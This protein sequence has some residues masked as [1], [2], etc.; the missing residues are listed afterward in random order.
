MDV[1]PEIRSSSE[2]RISMCWSGEP[3]NVT[4]CLFS[5]AAGIGTF[6]TQSFT[7]K[8]SINAGIK[9]EP[10]LSYQKDF[11]PSKSVI[12]KTLAVSDR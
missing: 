9:S 4:I 8:I 5:V 1:F 12:L 2:I 10:E 11:V 7:Q 3:W 6:F